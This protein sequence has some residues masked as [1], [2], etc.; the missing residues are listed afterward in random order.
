MPAAT[1]LASSP[2][3]VGPKMESRTFIVVNRQLQIECG[4]VLCHS[5]QRKRDY[6]GLFRKKENDYMDSLGAEYTRK[7]SIDD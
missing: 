4:L 5:R 7:D 1:R 2:G 6:Q 3:V